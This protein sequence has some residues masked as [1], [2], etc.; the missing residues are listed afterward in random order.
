[1]RVSGENV[2]KK[3]I[4][5]SPK[6]GG[7]SKKPGGAEVGALRASVVKSRAD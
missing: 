5:F 2:R 3:E 1:M 4:F 7:G 6:E